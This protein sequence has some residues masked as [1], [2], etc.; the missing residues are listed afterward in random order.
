[1]KHFSAA[2]T[3]HEPIARDTFRLCFSWPHDC[4][5]PLPGQ[6]IDIR[7]QQTTVP[8]LRRPFAIS[9]FDPATR[10]AEIIYLRRGTATALLA[11]KHIDDALD[12]LGPLGHTFTF[13]C[14]RAVLCAGGI[15]LGPIRF[16]HSYLCARELPCVLIAGFPSQ[17]AVPHTLLKNAPDTIVCTDDG[18]HGFHGTPVDYLSDHG[19]R[20]D[21]TTQLYVCGPW[22]LLRACHT[23]AL[24]A[25]CGCEVAVEQ[26]M[27]CGVGACMGCTIEVRRYPG[28]A[29]VC[30]EGP[31]FNSREIV[32]T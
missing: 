29:R 6:F 10:T 26:V 1:M 5:T 20:I 9:G 27:A 24:D 31:V 23:H 11:E 17:E 32:W 2:I 3:A 25:G 28:F 16:L 14:S 7:I 22:P 19:D 4:P 8:L 15:G 30:T 18:S 12:I 21:H 13:D